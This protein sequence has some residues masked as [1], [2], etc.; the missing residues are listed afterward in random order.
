MYGFSRDD[1]SRFLPTYLEKHI[2]ASNPFEVIDRNGTGINIITTTI[3]TIT[4]STSW[5]TFISI[6]P[7]DSNGD[8]KN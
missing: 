2:L 6:R 7:S 5:M 8:K 3:E 1:T 4:Y